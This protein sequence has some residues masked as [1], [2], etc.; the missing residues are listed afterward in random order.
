MSRIF[1]AYKKQSEPIVD[2]AREVNQVG[3]KPLFPTPTEIQQADFHKLANRLLGLRSGTNASV[4]CFASTTTGEGASFIS[5]NAAVILAQVYHQKVVWI[6]GNFLSPHAKLNAGDR[7]KF[8]ALLR[9]PEQVDHLHVDSNPYPIGSGSDLMGAKGL[10]ASQNYSQ[11]I[12]G[13]ARQFDFVILDLP[14]VLDS[15]D[16]ALMAA[17]CD[18]FLLVI[19]QKYLKWEVVE[20]GVGALRDKGVHVLGSVINRREFALP[21]IIYDRL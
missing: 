5:Y 15:N 1:D 4:L 12:D 2:L 21:K 6:D 9:D 19:E 8:S 3:F 10:F 13:L 17:G 20:H 11:V 16:T 7:V 14:P 18:G